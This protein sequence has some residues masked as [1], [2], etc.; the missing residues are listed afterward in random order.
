MRFRSSDSEEIY[1]VP[2]QKERQYVLVVDVN[3]MGSD[4][5]QNSGTYEAVSVWWLCVL[6]ACIFWWM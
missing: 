1:Y 2:E 4:F 6:H 3:K 5:G